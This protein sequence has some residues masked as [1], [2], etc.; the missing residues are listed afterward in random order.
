MHEPALPTALPLASSTRTRA[1]PLVR[2]LHYGSRGT[3]CALTPSL[4]CAT[5]SPH[6]PPDVTYPLIVLLSDALVTASKRSV[7]SRGVPNKLLSIHTMRLLN[8]AVSPFCALPCTPSDSGYLT[9]RP[10][11]RIA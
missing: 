11:L 5:R 3:S 4:T 2:T 8:V 9:S 6:A 10:D 1:T 7:F